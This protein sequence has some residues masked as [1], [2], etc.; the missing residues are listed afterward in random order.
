MLGRGEGPL[1]QCTRACVPPRREGSQEMPEILG[2]KLQHDMWYISIP[3]QGKTKP[4]CDIAGGLCRVCARLERCLD[5]GGK[6]TFYLLLGHMELWGQ[7]FKWRAS[8]VSP[9][10]CFPLLALSWAGLPQSNPPPCP[11]PPPPSAPAL[12]HECP[13]S[14]LRN[15]QLLAAQRVRDYALFCL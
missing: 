8:R 5:R 13:G 10:F 12:P 15:V 3:S 4:A 9:L 6:K 2:L 1:K 11:A 14:S 7:R